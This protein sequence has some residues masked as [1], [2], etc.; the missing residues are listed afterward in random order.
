MSPSSLIFKQT[1]EIGL[2]VTDSITYFI[3]QSIRERLKTGKNYQ[4]YRSLL[5]RLDQHIK[6]ALTDKANAEKIILEIDS[7]NIEESFQEIKTK[8]L[9]LAPQGNLNYEVVIDLEVEEGMVQIPLH[10]SHLAKDSGADLLEAISK[11]VHPL[12][13]QT[14]QNAVEITQFY[15]NGKD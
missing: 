8:V 6:S 5:E 10:C 9:E 12:I 4:E 14:R 7:Q 11:G 13:A 2:N 1:A 15:T 3:R